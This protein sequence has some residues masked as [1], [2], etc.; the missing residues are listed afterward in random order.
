MHVSFWLLIEGANR[1][2]LILR[3]RL[4]NIPCY[5]HMSK[6]YFCVGLWKH[7]VFTYSKENPSFLYSYPLCRN[8][9]SKIRFWNATNFDEILDYIYHISYLLRNL[10]N[11]FSLSKMLGELLGLLCLL[12]ILLQS[13]ISFVS[14]FCFRH[15]LLC[16]W[17]Y[18]NVEIACSLLLV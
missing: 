16:S 7:I 11:H 15:R 8:W 13:Y 2:T 10:I 5:A 6:I 9:F 17:T 3:W 18:T 4:C 12:L 1:E 14:S